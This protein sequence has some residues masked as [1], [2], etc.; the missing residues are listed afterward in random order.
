M[1]QA[2]SLMVPLA[3][4]VQKFIV[5]GAKLFNFRYHIL[6]CNSDSEM[7]IVIELSLF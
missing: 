3:Q 1:P 6:Y 4:P 2:T 7:I 5:H